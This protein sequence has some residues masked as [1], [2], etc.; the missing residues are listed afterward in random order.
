MSRPSIAI[1]FDD[2]LFAIA[3]PLI[4]YYNLNFKTQLSLG[5]YN[6]PQYHLYW[7]SD[8]DLMTAR[9][10]KFLSSDEIINLKPIPGAQASI[11]V[12][13]RYYDLH[14]VT[15]RNYTLLEPT[16]QMID[17][18]FKDNFASIN[19]TNHFSTK[20]KTKA[21]ILKELG[22][23]YLVDDNYDHLRLVTDQLKIPVI[24]FGDY[25]WQNNKHKDPAIKRAKTWSKTE[26]ILLSLQES[27]RIDG[28]RD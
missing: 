11:K 19:F 25:P 20:A 1:D 27:H 7:G 21:D 16:K 23:S 22:S 6:H 3:Q 2:V 28:A 24:L 12:L 14:L 8:L 13:S 4:D 5:H 18:N 17:K 26:K 10:N 15:A 9:I